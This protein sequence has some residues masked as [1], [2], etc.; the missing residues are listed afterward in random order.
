MKADFNETTWKACWALVVEG[1]QA[2]DVACELGITAGAVHAA[3]FRVLA[4][5]K[6]E[7]AGLLE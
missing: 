6:G 5:L 1:R 3:R 2:A 7:F 4:R